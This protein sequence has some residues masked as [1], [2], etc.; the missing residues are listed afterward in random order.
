MNEQIIALA[1]FIPCFV[2]IILRRFRVAYVALA[3]AGA[4]LLT[5]VVS[6]SQATRLID[7]N[8]LGM[9]W[10]FG[11]LSL[12]FI[13]SRVPAAIASSLLRRPKQ[14]KLIIFYLCCLAAFL[15]SF[16]YNP[17][18]VL[19]LAPI[20]METARRTG[21][22][23]FDY[24]IPLAISSNAVTTVTMVSDPPALI[25]AEKSSMGFLDFYWFHSK[26]GLG[27]ISALGAVAALFSLLWVFRTKTR[28]VFLAGE[29]IEVSYGA[30][31]LLVGGILALIFRAPPGLVG[32]GVGILSLA[33]MRNNLHR[34]K[35]F[36]W[37]TLLFI[38]GI[39]VVVGS[40]ELTRVLE[41][42]VNWFATLQI[43]NPS[44]LL[45]LVVWLSVGLSSF[46]DNVPFTLLM[47]PVCKG[48]ASGLGMSPMPLLYGMV[49]GTGIGGNLLP[50]GA[51]ANV[52]AC[53]MLEKQGYRVRLREYVR[54]ALPFTLLA[55]AVSHLL[56][57]LI[58]M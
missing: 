2:L 49:V 16:L 30:T 20:A 32:I 36:D 14:E 52:I 43:R 48:I 4:L 28:K 23:L 11:M 51:T 41:K 58:W 42:F 57:Q 46:I 55:V 17:V 29:K 24:L 47:I 18:V 5:R 1:V 53:G 26:I 50:V 25:L 34:L 9:C 13:Q 39:F 44:L 8:V 3:A 21:S 7:W 40:L 12:A 27:I 33:L 45:A 37:E 19:M 35:E 10:G 54:V 31:A 22:R 6:P 15:S 56:L 38:A